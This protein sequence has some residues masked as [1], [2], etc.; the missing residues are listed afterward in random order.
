MGVVGTGP[1]AP[2]K[3]A[4]AQ[5]EKRKQTHKNTQTSDAQISGR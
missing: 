4:N 2:C 1:V 3:G 5:S